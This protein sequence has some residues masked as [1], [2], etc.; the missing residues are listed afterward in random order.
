MSGEWVLRFE[1]VSKADLP[2]VGGKGA[3]LGELTRAGFSV[4]EGFCVTTAAFDAMLAGAPEMASRYQALEA[5][6]GNDVAKAK[7]EA[8]ATR[9]VL[10][11]APMP[12]GV[13]RAVVEAWR[14]RRGAT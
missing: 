14:A 9:A 2:K 5:L 10:M 4:P 1:N 11:A 6:D 7:V 13:R 3:N 12:D 8:E